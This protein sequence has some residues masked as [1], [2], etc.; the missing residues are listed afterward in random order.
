MEQLLYIYVIV[1]SVIGFL[2]MGMDKW[3]AKQKKWRIKESTLFLIAI[4]GGVIGSILGMFVFNHKTKHLTFKL[5]FFSILI[6]ESAIIFF[7][8]NLS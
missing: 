4:F 2:S 5:G 7:L 8:Y 1:M 6:I 3:K